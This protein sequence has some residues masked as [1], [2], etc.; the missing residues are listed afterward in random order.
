MLAKVAERRAEYG[1]SISK[2]VGYITRRKAP[3]LPDLATAEADL[4]E[5]RKS[6]LARTMFDPR[7]L[8]AEEGAN[9]PAGL[10]LARVSSVVSYSLN[11]V[12][13]RIFGSG[14]VSFL[15]TTCLSLQTAAAEMAGVAQGNGR[16]KEPFYHLIVSWR[17]GETP[18][19]VQ[20]W[21]VSRMVAET[22]KMD[23][24]QVMVA[25]HRDTAN[26]HMHLAFNRVH[27]QSG[28]VA[29]MFNSW[30]R[31]DECMRRC[32]LLQGWEPDVGPCFVA[33][34][35]ETIKRRPRDGGRLHTPYKARDMEL[36]SGRETLLT[37]SRR[38]VKE[39]VIPVLGQ[40]NPDWSKLNDALANVGLGL[41]PRGQGFVIFDLKES[42]IAVKASNVHERLGKGQLVKA[43]GAY[44][45]NART[46]SPMPVMEYDRAQPPNHRADSDREERRR[47]RA[48]ERRLLERQ[49]R[50]YVCFQRDFGPRPIGLSVEFK[51]IASV[52]RANKHQIRSMKEPAALK[53][54]M[55]S[56]AAYRAVC[57]K[58][59]AKDRV[60]LVRA[61]IRNDHPVL[62]WLEWVEKE[63]KLGN[64]AAIGVVRS[65][66]YGEQRRAAREEIR[67]QARLRN[68]GF[69]APDASN[70]I[71][72]DADRGVLEKISKIQPY[73]DRKT[74]TV[75]Y[76]DTSAVLFTDYGRVISL[77]PRAA[78]QPS[79]IE[80]GALLARQKFGPVITITGSLEFRERAL[81]TIIAA[82]IDVQL[83]DPDLEKRRLLSMRTGSQIRGE[84]VSGGIPLDKS[85]H[86]RPSQR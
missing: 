42:A 85:K 50:E 20:M 26:C 63:V 55:R 19:P 23:E 39:H 21:E 76:A 72:P 48:E 32:E 31:L 41:T 16:V 29:D 67:H 70:E 82:K 52:Y 44:M 12:P 3:E 25:G 75:S 45:A 61:R 8:V 34:D 38:V 28:L 79:A 2:L 77:E 78:Q 65:V 11:R 68:A 13:H 22:L 9:S 40:P 64:R 71:D 24:H 73:W 14:D 53:K 86:S 54:A 46:L 57:E 49:Y 62:S 37:Y 7:E 66:R 69:T 4:V 10:E 60:R 6:M 17:P 27:P 18:S 80:M 15:A 35:G 84:R 47:R 83:T 33:E 59:A 43:L 58:A 81:A 56:A 5:W 74:G 36:K 51:R 1:S 30:I